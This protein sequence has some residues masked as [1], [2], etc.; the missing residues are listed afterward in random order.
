MTEFK[1]GELIEVK[2]EGTDWGDY[3]PVEFVCKYKG[4]YIGWLKDEDEGDR[5]MEYDEARKLEKSNTTHEK[6]KYPD[7]K[8]IEMD[9]TH[10][11]VDVTLRLFSKM[12][13]VVSRVNY[14]HNLY[15][16]DLESAD[17]PPE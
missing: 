10:T 11:E 12:F 9:H 5:I 15:F 1:Q 14:L 8:Q 3:Y 4:K 2:L 6:K 17:V 16:K 13:E 7:I